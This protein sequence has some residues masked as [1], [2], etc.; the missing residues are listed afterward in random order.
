MNYY[1]TRAGPIE[2]LIFISET[3][4]I[5]TERMVRM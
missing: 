2:G 4:V 1:D 3:V 5:V